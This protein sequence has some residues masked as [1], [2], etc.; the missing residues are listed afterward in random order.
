MKF[1]NILPL[2]CQIWNLTIHKLAC[3]IS[4][5]VRLECTLIFTVCS[6]PS[7]PHGRLLLGK[8]SWPNC[9]KHCTHINLACMAFGRKINPHH[10]AAVGK[11]GKFW[12][13]LNLSFTPSLSRIPGWQSCKRGIYG[14]DANLLVHSWGFLVH[15]PYSQIWAL[16]SEV[17]TLL[18]ARCSSLLPCSQ[19]LSPVHIMANG[20]LVRQHR[21]VLD[22]VSIDQIHVWLPRHLVST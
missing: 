5:F 19:I 20:L 11:K 3:S 6:S 14:L 16:N 13:S 8:G 12:T 7:L 1:K 18:S 15:L 10:D 21:T 4:P 2:V 22:L 9:S 17:S